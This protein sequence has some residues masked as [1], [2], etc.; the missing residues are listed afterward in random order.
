LFPGKAF[1]NPLSHSK[2]RKAW[3]GNGKQPSRFHVLRIR[4]HGIAFA[5]HK[6]KKLELDIYGF[7]GTPSNEFARYKI[8][9]KRSYHG[10][11]GFR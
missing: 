4:F 7:G 8:T 2:P 5:S 11:A 6:V 10:I 1:A 9:L 3:T